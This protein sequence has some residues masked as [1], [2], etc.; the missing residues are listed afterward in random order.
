M[1]NTLTLGN[2][3]ITGN[4]ITSGSDTSG[5]MYY[6]DQCI[7]ASSEATI[8]ANTIGGINSSGTAVMIKL[9][10]ESASNVI[11]NN[12]FYRANSVIGAYI[13]D[14]SL[15]TTDHIITNNIFDQPTVDGTNETICSNLSQGTL[16]NNNKNQTG[17][18]TIPLGPNYTNLYSGADIQISN[19][20]FSVSTPI[21]IYS[22]LTFTNSGGAKEE[23]ATMYLVNISDYLPA[24]TKVLNSV[25][26]IAFSNNGIDT[27]STSTFKCDLFETIN[28]NYTLSTLSQ[29]IADVYYH[30]SIADYGAL[31][32]T[33]RTSNILSIASPSD[34][35]AALGHTTFLSIDTSSFN[36]CSSENNKI[37]VRIL[38]DVWTAA[39]SQVQVEQSPLI[40]KYRW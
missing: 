19:V 23:A 3:L 37:F 5:T 40:I 28:T 16:Y 18:L 30:V 24:G 1:S 34:L 20:L 7:N 38:Y 8:Q 26:G 14:A 31:I 33:Q 35:T 21:N 13:A 11:V 9:G 36:Y 29:S 17:Y 15:S 6:Y 4:I 2:T 39:S 32:A 25:L 27:T 10:D 12:T 22:A